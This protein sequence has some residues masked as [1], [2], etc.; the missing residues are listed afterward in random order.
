M[1]PAT[2]KLEAAPEAASIHH[3]SRLA[4][5]KYERTLLDARREW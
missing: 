3:F 1:V 4:P 5:R 2:S